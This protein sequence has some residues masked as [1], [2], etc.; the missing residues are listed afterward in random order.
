MSPS[1]QRLADAFVALAH[2]LDDS[3][4]PATF[5][6]VLSERSADLL[7]VQAAG[8]VLV[9]DGPD[10]PCVSGS[11]P[12]IA[13]LESEAA[14]AQ[15]GPGHDCRLK[16]SRAE[17]ALDAQAQLRWPMYTSRA[18]ALGFTRVAALPLR[19][20]DTLLGALVLLRT[21]GAPLPE[22]ALALGQSLADA[23]TVALLR[24]HEL[25][26]S[27]VLTAQLEQAL[28]S[29]IVLE[30]AKGVLATR[31]RV[32]VDEAFVVL[33]TH[34]RANQLKLS[35]VALAVVEGRL[36]LPES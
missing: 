5:L 33:R 27:R 21:D 32:T 19:V 13:A 35:E 36:Y 25:N 4:V 7:D 6:T 18:R 28:T 23:A 29:R 16:G 1:D 11:D 12:R 31:L 2:V 8:A 14:Q 3:F 22:D 24:Q 30:Q 15:E 26:K 9:M 34:A 10:F 20:C 17:T